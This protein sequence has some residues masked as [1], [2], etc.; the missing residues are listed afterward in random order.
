MSRQYKDK[1][2]TG[3]QY[4]QSLRP[5][6][7]IGILLVFNEIEKNNNQCITKHKNYR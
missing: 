2:I 7:L 4:Y 5:S 1:D 6:F 3:D